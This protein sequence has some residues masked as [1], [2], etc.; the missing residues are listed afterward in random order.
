MHLRQPRQRRGLLTQLPVHSVGW[1]RLRDG[2]TVTWHDNRV[3]VLPDA[4]DDVRW[5][6][7]LVVDGRPSALEGEVR[8]IPA[9]AWWPWLVVGLPFVLVSLSIL[10]WR[11]SATRSAAAAF[12][13]V[14]AGGALASNAGFAFDTYASSGKWVGVG[15]TLVFVLVGAAVIARA[16]PDTRGIAGGALGLLALWAGLTAIPVLLHGVVLSIF[17]PTEA[18]ALVALTLWSAAAAT[19][20]GLA[21]V[22]DQN[23]AEHHGAFR[24]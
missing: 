8:R 12:G 22:F 2:R 23:T 24:V 19:A 4:V 18:R 5:R 15:D 1:H 14:A 11:R 10:V 17:P 3:R 16:S 20:L 6:I 9:P 7:P 21:V 13:L